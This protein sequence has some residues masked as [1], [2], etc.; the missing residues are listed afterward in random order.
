MALFA[1]RLERVGGSGAGED[2]YSPYL[3]GLYRFRRRCSQILTAVCE[4]EDSQI[5]RAAILGEK[6]EIPPPLRPFG[7]L[8][9]EQVQQQSQSLLEGV[10][11]RALPLCL[12][13][14]FILIPVIC[15]KKLRESDTEIGYVVLQKIDQLQDAAPKG[16]VITFFTNTEQVTVHNGRKNM[17]KQ[18][19]Q[20]VLLHQAYV[21]EQARQE[22]LALEG[23]Q[24]YTPAEEI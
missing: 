9:P 12:N 13:P 6:E 8:E 22:A 10:R 4:E 11:S 14:Y 2:S 17:R 19:A 7:K 23:L 20:G 16:T 18:I 21:Q 1:D 24:A 15:R 3:D 5:F